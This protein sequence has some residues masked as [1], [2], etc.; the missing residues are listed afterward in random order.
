MNE[1][2]IISTILV[3]SVGV[4][5]YFIGWINTTIM[6][7]SKKQHVLGIILFLLSPL[8]VIY[9]IQHWSEAAKQGKQMILGLIIFS[10]TAIPAY[11]YVDS[12]AM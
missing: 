1:L 9:C 6:A 3:G 8:S 5:L 11:L 7:L 2:I 10:M 12:L 4:L